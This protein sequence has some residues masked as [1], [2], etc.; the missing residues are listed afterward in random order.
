MQE[1]TP[2]FPQATETQLL[3]NPLAAFETGGR[4]LSLT[5]A[6]SPSWPSS[7]TPPPRDLQTLQLTQADAFPHLP[8]PHLSFPQN[9]SPSSGFLQSHAFFVFV[10]DRGENKGRA[11]FFEP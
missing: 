1:E 2:P 5:S 9:R 4:T 11:V 6:S 8:L 7:S 10:F 3:P